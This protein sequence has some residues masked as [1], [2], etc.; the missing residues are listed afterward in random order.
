[1]YSV[2]LGRQLGN[3]PRKQ[4]QEAVA[5]NKKINDRKACPIPVSPGALRGWAQRKRTPASYK[6]PSWPPRTPT[7]DRGGSQR[8]PPRRDPE[9]HSLTRQEERGEEADDG[10]TGRQAKWQTERQSERRRADRPAGMQAGEPRPRGR[11]TTGAQDHLSIARLQHSAVQEYRLTLECS[12]WSSSRPQERASAPVSSVDVENKWDQFAPQRGVE[13]IFTAQYNKRHRGAHPLDNNDLKSALGF[14][15]FT[16]IVL[17]L[18]KVSSLAP[19]AISL[20]LS[21]VDMTWSSNLGEA[22]S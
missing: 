10:W 7:P 6:T 3:G 15:K 9:E 19:S 11:E 12:A 2:P 17:N 8:P 14:S 20:I 1:M 13:H 18:P 22:S 5:P 16:S 21:V 4:K